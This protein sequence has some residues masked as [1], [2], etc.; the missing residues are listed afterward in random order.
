MCLGDIQYMHVVAE[1]SAIGRRIIIPKNIE[2]VALPQYGLQEQWNNVSFWAMI[3]PDSSGCSACIEITKRDN[4]PPISGGIPV[5]NSLQH[6]LALAIRVNGIFR[7]VLLNR[8][9]NWVSVNSCRRGKNEFFN[10]RLSSLFQKS[11]ARRDICFKE[12]AGIDYRFGNQSFGS[13]MKNHIET[14]TG[15]YFRHGLAIAYIDA[16][17]NY[18]RRK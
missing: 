7:V 9:R 3:L 2:I 1:T 14:G 13:E 12:D 18:V 6:Q 17:Q 8:S 15:K 16:M 4:G 11:D 10:A 5:Q